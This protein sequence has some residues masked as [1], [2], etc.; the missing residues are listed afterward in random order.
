MKILYKASCLHVMKT[1]TNPKFGGRKM[2]EGKFAE[3][4]LV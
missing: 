2:C 1:F 3:N 4:G